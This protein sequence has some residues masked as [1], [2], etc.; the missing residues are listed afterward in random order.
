M[1]APEV[2]ATAALYGDPPLTIGQVKRVLEWWSCSEPFRK[3]I[4]ADPERAGREY[5]L[6]FD[7]EIMRPLWD[8]FDALTAERE[9]RPLH[10]VVGAYRQFFNAK[11]KWRD[12]IKEECS[13]DD[14]RFKAWRT[15]QIARNA[16]ENGAYDDYIIHTPLAIEITDGCSVGCWFCGV[17]ATKLAKAW[18]YTQENGALWRAT[19]KV[20]RDKIGHAAKWGFCY[21]A[22]DPLDNPDYERF[23]GDFCD[24]VGMYP[25]T[26]TAQ[27]HKDPE[28]VRNILRVSQSRGCRVNRFSVLTEPLLRRV[29]AAFTPD[30]LTGV[31]I[32]AQMK[33][34]TVPKAAAGAF[35]ERA[36]SKKDIVEVEHRK[37]AMLADTSRRLAG[38]AGQGSGDMAMTQPGTIA[39]V[40]GFLLN[41]VTRTVKLISPCRANDKWPLGYIVFEER[42]FADA[43]DLDRHLEEM[44]AE[45]MPLTISLH[46][47]MRFLP[48]LNYERVSDGF[49][50]MTPL[51]ALVMRRP[52]LGEYVGALGDKLFKGDRTAG[53]IALSS[54]FEH[55]IPEINTLG[56]LATLFQ[57][58]MLVDAK[59]RVAGERPPGTG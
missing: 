55:G 32:V 38:D 9:K 46:D 7:P 34:G 26:T 8:P 17:G 49:Q 50:V 30:E 11:K 59:G 41:M 47:R 13:P 2:A 53:Q 31:E 10:P 58:G 6:G 19:V 54:F 57:R 39:C 56:T 16:L 20:L 4:A 22:T 15:R 35:R 25:Q 33:D 23:A 43:A 1:T 29:F 36:K 28:R 14:P 3:L 40:S 5:K 52:E 21:W 45:H 12:E 51:N 27:A 18:P 37:L 48:E 24:I 42:T 44:I